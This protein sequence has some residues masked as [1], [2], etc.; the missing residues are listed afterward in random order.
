MTYVS[1][2]K[3]CRFC[4]KANWEDARPFVKYGPRHHA[5]A[6]CYL[7]AGK[8]ISRLSY[9][10]AARLPFFTLKELGLLDEVKQRL[11]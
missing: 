9:D 11:G 3:H 8:P 5:H 4:K 2:L 10:D 1:D 6:E 7:R